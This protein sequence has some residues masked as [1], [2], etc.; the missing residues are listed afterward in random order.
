MRIRFY[1][2]P[3]TGEPHIYEHGVDEDEVKDV[4]EDPI[5]DDKAKGNSRSAM[6]QTRAGRYVLVIYSRDPEPN[7]VFVITARELQGKELK[8]LKR[9]RR[10][11]L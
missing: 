7:S 4:L 10:K 3:E 1:I 2:D 8:A 9:R 6:G 5:Y 11:K